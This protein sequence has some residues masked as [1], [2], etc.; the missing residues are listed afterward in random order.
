M[1]DTTGAGAP[2]CLAPIAKN[3]E[4]DPPGVQVA[5]TKRP[6]GLH[7]RASSPAAASWS[8]A[9]ITPKVEITRSNEASPKGNYSAS[10]SW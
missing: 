7:T 3:F 8:L 5:S 2:E 9:N 4:T 10:A 1:G 6:P